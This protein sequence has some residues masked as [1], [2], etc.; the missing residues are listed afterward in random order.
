M[1]DVVDWCPEDDTKQ[2]QD[3][4]RKEDASMDE[5]EP[6]SGS[7]EHARSGPEPSMEDTE[8]ACS[9]LGA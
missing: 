7:S 4:A 6:A 3:Q 2:E 1:G 9:G 8:H 5:P